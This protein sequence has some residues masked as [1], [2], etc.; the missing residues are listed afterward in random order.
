MG[1]DRHCALVLLAVAF[2]AFLTACGGAGRGTGL[3]SKTSST[4]LAG[5]ADAQTSTAG[6]GLALG[7]ISGD[8]D[9]DDDYRHKPSNDG[10][11]DDLRTRKDRD[12]DADNRSKSYYDK[13]DHSV[14]GFGHAARAADRSAIAALVRRYF[15]VAAAADGVAA[16]SM[17]V[18][19]FA[20][21]VPEDLG[22][23][24][25]PPYSRG[26]TCAVVMSKTFE[27]YHRQLAAH[28]ASLEVSRV[29]VEGSMGLAVLA[30][31]GLPGRQIQVAREGGVWMMD[32][33]LD[34]ELP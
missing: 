9:T 11:N 21:S 34:R 27:H 31:K 29:R 6:T 3:A 30:F 5:Q 2:C 17:I 19:S 12:N 7:E 18:P 23:S 33:L 15:A 8:Y 24:P 14:L 28:A 10:D 13:D 1:L 20:K 25:G 26:K 4:V 32:A 22:Q 16:C